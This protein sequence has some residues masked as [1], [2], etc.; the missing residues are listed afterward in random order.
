MDTELEAQKAYQWRRMQYAQLI[1]TINSLTGNIT[2]DLNNRLTVINSNIDAVIKQ[3][4]DR[5][6]LKKKLGAALTAVER[7]S[8]LM[9][10][11]ASFANH[12]NW[13]PQ[14]VDIA[15]GLNSDAIL[16]RRSL[17]SET[18]R[19]EV[20]VADDIWPVEIDPDQLQMAIINMSINAR[21]AMPRG[22]IIKLAA[23]NV[24]L[25]DDDDLNL[26]GDFVCISVSDTGTGVAPEHID[27]VFQPFFTTKEIRN[28]M[29]LGLSQVKNMALRVGGDVT[30]RSDS[31]VGTTLFLYL[32]RACSSLGQPV[33]HSVAAAEIPHVEILVVEDEKDVASALESMVFQLG[34]SVRIA[35][36]SLE[37]LSAIKVEKPDLVLTDITMPGTMDGIALGRQLRHRYPSLPIILMTGNPLIAPDNEDFSVLSKPVTSEKLK[38]ALDLHLAHGQD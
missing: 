7:S 18:V 16:I 21:E 28:G 11:L 34:H 3:L 14:R 24:T 23:S 8:N 9:S 20:N 13:Q 32:P 29:G 37:A 19:I 31:G 4:D 38:A 12:R 36:G 25:H 35:H 10:K 27:K 1:D 30:I 22:G 2:H 33:A 6:A 5:P 17:L 26:Y 15:E